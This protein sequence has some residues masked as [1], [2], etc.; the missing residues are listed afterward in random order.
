M[1]SDMDGYRRLAVAVIEQALKDLRDPI[2]EPLDWESS[3]TFFLGKGLD[4]WIS[5]LETSKDQLLTKVRPYIETAQRRLACIHD[6]Y[7]RRVA[8]HK[9]AMNVC[10][11]CGRTVRVLTVQRI[12]ERAREVRDA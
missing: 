9:E 6:Y 3:I 4:L 5:V 12:V 2:G 1:S 10:K 11:Q 8:G 7:S